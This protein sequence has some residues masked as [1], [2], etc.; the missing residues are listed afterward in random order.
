[1]LENTWDASDLV[2]ITHVELATGG[3]VGDVGHLVGD[4]VEVVKSEIDAGLVSDS[5][6][7]ENSVGGST[8]R[9]GQ[10]NRVLER[11]LGHDL[12]RRDTE[13]E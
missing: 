3:H 11:S 6:Q 12:A 2:E 7:M 9:R 13:P 5:K 4:P 8:E 1:M 10:R